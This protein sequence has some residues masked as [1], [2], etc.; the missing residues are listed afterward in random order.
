MRKSYETIL[1]ESVWALE[2]QIETFAKRT[3]LSADDKRIALGDLARH[4]MN[5]RE[6]V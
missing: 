6:R 4:C 2:E 3:D 5:Q 1:E